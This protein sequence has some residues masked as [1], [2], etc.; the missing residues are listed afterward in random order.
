VPSA[1]PHKFIAV[2]ADGSTPVTYDPCRPLSYVVNAR[3]APLGGDILLTDAVETVAQATGLQFQFEGFT[4]E[5]ATE[6][7]LDFQ[8]ARYGD[9][10]API[11]I[12]WSDPGEMPELQGDV[13]GRGGSVRISA[14]LGGPVAYVTGGVF[15]DGPQLGDLLAGGGAVQA[16]GTVLHELGHLVGLDHIDDPAQL[17]HP[18][19]QLGEFQPGD[20]AGLARLGS[21]S[22]FRY[23]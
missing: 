4:D 20:L 16:R 21:G 11:L 13:T 5:P 1:G 6:D 19:G 9:R 14:R 7:R 17:M 10:W 8:R 3:T 15:L 12:A 18:T 2:Q 22:C 23:L